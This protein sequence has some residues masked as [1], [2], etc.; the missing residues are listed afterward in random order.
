MQFF[1]ISTDNADI[2]NRSK[3]IAS[4]IFG[5]FEIVTDYNNAEFKNYLGKYEWKWC[6]DKHAI[7][8][9]SAV[10]SIEKNILL[11]TGFRPNGLKPIRREIIPINKFSFRTQHG[12]F[13]RMLFGENGEVAGIFISHGP[14]FLLELKKVR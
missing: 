1:F 6:T 5:Q 10:V 9:D 8:D 4:H 7:A 12:G 11:Y 2:K 3:E 14:G 13:Y